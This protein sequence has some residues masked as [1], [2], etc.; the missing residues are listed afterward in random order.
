MTMARA[1]SPLDGI[2]TRIMRHADLLARHTEVP[3]QLTRTFLTPVQRAAA[4]TLM[5]W[6]RDAGMSATLDAIG[7]VVGRYEGAQA[8]LPALMFG[9]HFDSVRNGGRYDGDLGVIAPI[10]C[11]DA[12]HRAGRRLPF[13]VE[14]VAFAD[15]EG[16]RFQAT[17]LGSK[18]V[19]GT[20][21]TG[22]LSKRD[23]DG[24]S[25]AEALVA[26][27][28]DPARV[29]AAARRREEI[30]AYCELHIEQGPV[31]LAEGLPVG[32][33]T[34]IVGFDRFM[35]HAT[36]LAGHAGTVPMPLRRDAAAAAAEIV[37]FVERRCRSVDG[38]VGT[39]GQ[40]S[41]L[42][43]ATNVIPGACEF[44]L[45]VR[46]GDDA[47]RDAAVADIL[48]EIDAV[49]A[50]RGV[51]FAVTPTQQAKRCACA[52]WLMDQL[53]AAV[54]RAGVRP[55]RLPSGA[56][57]DA[58]AIAPLADVAML[59]VRCGNGGISHHPDETMSEADADLSARIL[60]DFIVHFDLAARPVS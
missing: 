41:V 26:Y 20:F 15:E 12:L 1:G 58:M 56:G 6:M 4:D 57:H 31:L 59:F 40:L 37:L 16:V 45:D 7:N 21:D 36:G 34:S 35:V 39:V 9:S 32:V 30:L 54:A 25:M 19:A 42:Q 5:G 43:G 2:G 48:A 17:L 33:V 44:S 60:H 51:A 18:A 47:V 55:R 28:L 8:G 24:V 49:G 53:D 23:A 52:P 14:V 10:A 46:S 29:A 13:A 50:R 11:V 22:L 3:G 38:L 27:G